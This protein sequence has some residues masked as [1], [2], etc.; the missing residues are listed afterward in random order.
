MTRKNS[1][2]D[3]LKI[4][5]P[6]F[7]FWN[8]LFQIVRAINKLILKRRFLLVGVKKSKT[9]SMIPNISRTC[10]FKKV[11][12]NLVLAI[13]QSFWWQ[14]GCLLCQ[15]TNLALSFLINVFKPIRSPVI[16][17]EWVLFLYRLRGPAVTFCHFFSS[18]LNSR[19]A[20]VHERDRFLIWG[21]TVH[22]MP[23][24]TNISVL[25]T[26]TFD[27]GAHRSL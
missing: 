1:L 8:F 11:I 21:P 23:F 22:F 18:Q 4:S 16:Y 19:F 27:L 26:Q 2:Q 3:S 7:E 14:C 10:K 6:V 15:N 20:Q 17:P 24:F 12:K 13:K 9:D 5:I 25:P